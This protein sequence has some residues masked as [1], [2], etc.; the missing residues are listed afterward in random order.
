M[1]PLRPPKRR[2]RSPPAPQPKPRPRLRAKATSGVTRAPPPA[3]PCCGAPQL[4]DRSAWRA[5]AGCRRTYRCAAALQPGRATAAS[6]HAP[7]APTV[8]G[9]GGSAGG[10]PGPRR[11][12]S[13]PRLCLAAPCPAASPGGDIPLPIPLPHPPRHAVVQL[14]PPHPPPPP[15]PPLRVGQPTAAPPFED[16]GTSP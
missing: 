12:P 16:G 8:R 1:R 4:G 11:N 9:G 6:P 15:P 13:R 5:A 2:L 3:P 14:S 10:R 7:P